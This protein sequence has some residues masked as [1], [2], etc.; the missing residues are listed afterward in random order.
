MRGEKKHSGMSIAYFLSSPNETERRKMN[1]R[2]TG[3]VILTFME[4]CGLRATAAGASKPDPEIERSIREK[5]S[6][7]QIFDLD[8]EVE[9][10][11]KRGLVTLSGIVDTASEK[12]VAES[13][14]FGSGAKEVRN[15]LSVRTSD[16]E[17]T[18]GELQRPVMQPS[19]DSRKKR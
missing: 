11:V 4:L 18:V 7:N 16:P 3:I 1:A 17:A 12:K 5:L 13:A 2:E 14:A 8:D 10:R 19:A 6:S 9:V 15:N